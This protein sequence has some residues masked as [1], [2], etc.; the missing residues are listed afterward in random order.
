MVEEARVGGR[1]RAR[2]AADRRL[3]DRDHLVERLEPLDRAVRARPDAHPV[4]PV[5]QRLVHDLVDERRLAR[6]GDARDRDEAARPGSRR[7]RRAGCAGSRRARAATTS[8]GVRRAGTAI[9]RR[10]DRNAPVS[11][12]R[13]RATCAARALGDDLAAV[14]AGAGAHVDQPVGG[15]HRLLVVLDDDHGVAEVAQALER[16]D[17]PAVVAL[18]QPDRRL[19]EDVEHAHE[20]RAD[21][22]R[23]PDALRLAAGQR[24]GAARR[25][26]GS[27]ARRRRGR[28]AARRSRAGRARR[29]CDRSRRARAA[30]RTRAPRAPTSARTGRC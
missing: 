23:E 17:Q 7:R 14:H 11:E 5:L 19:V 25:A 24:R 9:L 1:V 26:R 10:P 16:R 20:A 18:V 15:A 13:L 8:P 4:Q 29:S 28:S 21:L 12:P 22:R 6:A 27:R 2:R 30:R 3:V